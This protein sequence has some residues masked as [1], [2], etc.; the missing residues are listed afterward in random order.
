MDLRNKNILI[1]DDNVTNC[2]VLQR[3]LSMQGLTCRTAYDGNTA[4][5]YKSLAGGS[6]THANNTGKYNT[7]I[8]AVSYT[9]LTLPTS[10]LV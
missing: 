5:G 8:G 7:A 9:H 10:D 4:I 1:V 3:R 2:E 6:G